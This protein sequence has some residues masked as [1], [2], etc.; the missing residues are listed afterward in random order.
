MIPGEK[1]RRKRGKKRKIKEVRRIGFRV[2]G[3]N[4]DKRKD[5]SKKG[6]TEK[7]NTEYSIKM[8]IQKSQC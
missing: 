7:R 4:G 3:R 2:A 6:K 8:S 5:K 1:Q